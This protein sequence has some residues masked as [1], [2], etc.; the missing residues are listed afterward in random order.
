MRK[1][2]KG[3]KPGMGGRKK[4][5]AMPGR[6]TGAPAK[7][8]ARKVVDKKVEARNKRLDKMPM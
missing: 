5:K 6:T 1:M 4:E 2:K 7:G 8:S 3:M